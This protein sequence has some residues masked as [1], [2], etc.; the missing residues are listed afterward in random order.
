MALTGEMIDAEE[1]LRIG[2]VTHVVP[3]GEL[4]DRAKE[5]L[6]KVTKNGPLAVRMVL[7][8]IYR[9]LDTTL[10]EANGV[11]STLFRA[12]GLLGGHEGGNDRLPG[13]AEARIQRPVRGPCCRPRD[14]A[15]HE[16]RRNPLWIKDFRYPGRGSQESPER[17]NSL[18]LKGILP[19]LPPCT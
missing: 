18:M 7:E 13:E 15:L 14:G 17:L 9:G 2:L 6:R 5:T 12:P 10:V 19:G 4:L 1:A 8:S 16:T 11:E 3:Q